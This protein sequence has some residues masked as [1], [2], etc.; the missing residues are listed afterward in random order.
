MGVQPSQGEV[1]ARTR[2]PL[3]VRGACAVGA[4]V[5]ILLAACQAAASA[6]VAER[7]DAQ[8]APRRVLRGTDAIGGIDDWALQNGTLCAVVSDPSHYSNLAITGGTLI[9]LGYCGR[10]DDQFLIRQPLLNNSL[11]SPAPVASVRAE[12]D[13][14]EARLV[15]SGEQEGIEVVTHYALDLARPERM[16]IETRVARTGPGLRLYGIAGALANVR[17]LS[18]FSVSTRNPEDGRGFV[19]LAYA[20]LGLRALGA[21]ASP[22]DAVIAVGAAPLE[23]GIAYG[24]RLVGA[25]LERA[26]GERVEV[27][28]FFLVDGL[29]TVL[30]TFARPFWLG[31]GSS[32]GLLQLFQTRFMDLSEGDGLVFLE[33]I[34]VGGRAD[35][36]SVTDLLF[37]DS[38]L[39]RGRADDPSA[40]IHV[41]L[42]AGGAVTQARAAS[43][44]RFA[45][46]LPPGEYALRALADGGR[47]V[48]RTFTQTEAGTDLGTL[49]VGAPGRLRLPRGAPMR[50]VFVGEDE[51]PSP[52]FDDDLRGFRVTLDEGMWKMPARND[53]HL[54]GGARDPAEVTLQPGRYRVFATLGPEFSLGEARVEIRP[55]ETSDLEIH[56]PTREVETPGWISS[57]FHVHAAHSLDSPLRTDTRV[58]SFVAQGGEVLVS[59]DHDAIYDYAPLIGE[60]GLRERLASVVG[61]E[62]TSEVP[63]ELTPHT[64]GHA[65]AFPMPRKPYAYQRGA[66]ADEGRRWRDIIAELRAIPGERVIQLNHA[67]Y[68]PPEIQRRAFLTHMGPAAAP[69]EPTL[70]L[71]EAPN[72]TL[73]EPDPE[74]G[75]RD[76]DFDAMELIIGAH[77]EI[78]EPLRE[79]WF[80]FLRQGERITATANSDSHFLDWV[81]ASP[82]NYVRVARDDVR[83]LD[84][85]AFVRAIGAGRVYSTTGPL[86]ELELG[87]A[88]IGETFHG[89]EAVLQAR[90]LA[91]SWVPVSELRVF[92]NG[93]PV[94]TQEVAPGASIE[95]PLRFER[96]AFVTV[97]VRGEPSEA[98]EAVL[99]GFPRS[100]SRTR[101]GWTPTA[102]SAGRRRG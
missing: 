2:S 26:S 1:V 20:G 86:L 82:R 63:T 22:V 14:G 11:T 76:L 98:Y 78:Y 64:N 93:E 45:L 28:H 90:V 102:T 51:T 44:G 67:R 66:V 50:L 88:E 74:T 37:A 55:G 29:A 41:S 91:A 69:Y 46:R 33:E 31:D 5:C 21:A 9:D 60:L 43:D 84:V 24:Q 92:V 101:S 54:T 61:L 81:V 87:G 94:S 97:E 62:I 99:P 58:A 17:S 72:R 4:A 15:A 18:P 83:S 23:P 73:I 89:G 100:P 52:N 53:L 7:I 48:E 79:D 42:A 96:D 30:A 32:L 85:A 12:V 27:P 13:N 56:A 71:D 10:P 77:L 70:P 68:G 59:T 57:D 25:Y 3:G 34:W 38:P 49:E 40:V 35:V 47:E 16:R 39:L 8:N 95:V 6:L 36:A 19:H 80:S 65:N 75:V